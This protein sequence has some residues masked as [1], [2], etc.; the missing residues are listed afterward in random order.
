MAPQPRPPPWRNPRKGRDQILPS[1]NLVTLYKI[2]RPVLVGDDV[3][4]VEVGLD[5][6]HHLR[7]L[8]H[9]LRVRHPR[10]LLPHPVPVLL[11]LLNE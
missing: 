8:E 6:P 5:P 1:G 9:P 7:L 4:V 3:H 11:R 2:D 10:R